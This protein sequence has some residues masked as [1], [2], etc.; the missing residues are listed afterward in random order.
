MPQ[1][2]DRPAPPESA[3]TAPEARA[4]TWS[5][6]RHPVFRA[7]WIASLASNF[8]GMIQ[9]V[10]AAWMMTSISGSPDMVALVTASVT[11]PIMLLALVSGAAADSF[12]RR[13]LM[14]AAQIFM[15]VVSVALT[16]CAWLGVLTPWLLLLFTFL[17]GC[18]SAFN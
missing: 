12:D 16:L 13:R 17:I 10:G 8:G 14:L 9:S 2:Q 18:G 4:G 5:A 3:V 15:L 6:L 11:L 7:I 1:Q